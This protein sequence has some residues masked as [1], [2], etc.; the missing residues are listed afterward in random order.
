MTSES[1][2]TSSDNEW[3]KP[4]G[5]CRGPW[6]ADHCHA[7]PPTGL[8]ARSAELA[9]PDKQLARLTVNLQR[10]IPFEG[11]RIFTEISKQGRQVSLARSYLQDSDERVCAS[12]ESLHIAPQPTTDY[13]TAHSDLPPFDSAVEGE[14]PIARTLHDLPSFTGDGVQTRYAPG[15]N[16]APGPTIAWIKTVP[17][18]PDETPSPFQ[19]MCPMA[20]CGNA[21]GRNVEPWEANF[22]NADLTIILFRP[23]EGEWMGSHA[24]GHWASNGIGL[25]DATLLDEKGIVGRAAQTLLIRKS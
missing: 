11:F 6:H 23:P 8:L 25:A 12:S 5:H 15:N 3:F 14:F 22:P 24:V 17:L 18:L 20:D 4:T 19:R 1:F 21:F 7:G 16:A 10:P 2:F 13:P 9:L